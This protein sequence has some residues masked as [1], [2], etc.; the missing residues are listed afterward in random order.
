MIDSHEL[1]ITRL[2]E[3]PTRLMRIEMLNVLMSPID[4][5]LL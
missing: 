2:L 3:K 5:R 4:E 1:S